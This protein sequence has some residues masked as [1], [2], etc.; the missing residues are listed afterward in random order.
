[1]LGRVWFSDGGRL[2][3][4]RC[5]NFI[6]GAVPPVP[7]VP[8][9]L[10][11]RPAVIGTSPRMPLAL[12]LGLTEAGGT[13]GTA[14]TTPFCRGTAALRHWASPI[15]GRRACAPFPEA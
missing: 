14:G 2:A 1:M 11:A 10:S 13:A 12:R 5:A 7:G 15:K 3:V 9:V 8:D 4:V 6:K